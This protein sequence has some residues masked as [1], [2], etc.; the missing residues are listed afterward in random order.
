M[1]YI[2]C[3][4][5]VVLISTSLSAGTW[6]MMLRATGGTMSVDRAELKWRR[7]TQ[8]ET[9]FEINKLP[10]HTQDTP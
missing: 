10:G 2:C 8:Q 3:K 4:S 6:T 1:P 9:R 5:S 7:L